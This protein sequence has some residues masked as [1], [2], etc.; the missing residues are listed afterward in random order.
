M[1]I[2]PRHLGG[3]LWS[4]EESER[5]IW[6]DRVYSLG[7]R[8]RYIDG[9]ET[10]TVE[11]VEAVPNDFLL[12]VSEQCLQLHEHGVVEDLA[13]ARLEKRCVHPCGVCFRLLK[14]S[15]LLLVL[16]HSRPT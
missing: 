4:W 15:G 14:P 7:G 1:S 6:A 5:E 12:G 16:A 10:N 8:G 9:V 2:L 13:V 11:E 3:Q